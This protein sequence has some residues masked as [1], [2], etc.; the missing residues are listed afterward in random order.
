MNICL[1]PIEEVQEASYNPRRISAYELAGLVESIRNFGCTQPLIVNKTT[2]ILVA[3]HQRLKAM[4]KLEYKEVPVIY[5]ELD[6]VKE[7][8]LNI[9]MN[10]KHIT[11]E[12]TDELQVIIDEIKNDVS[13]DFLI[14][15]N[16]DALII[17][18]H[19]EHK[20]H[21]EEPEEPEE[22]E[23]NKPEIKIKKCPYCG[24]SL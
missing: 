11:G 17:E 13:L 12:F 7:K 14:D 6:K 18:E 24:E 22:P 21:K 5:V 4:K 20:E 10:N 16:L 1:V 15:L 3:G 2:G 9:T 19:K 23:E 8:A